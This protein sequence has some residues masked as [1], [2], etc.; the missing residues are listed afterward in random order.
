MK[1]TLTLLAALLFAPLAALHA[2]EA[3]RPA[4]DVGLEGSVVSVYPGPVPKGALTIASGKPAALWDREAYPLGNG[5][6]GAMIFGG[7]SSDAIAL[8]EQTFWSNGA[9]PQ[10]HQPAEARKA[11][12]H[13][14]EIRR[15]LQERK[16]TEAYEYSR[17]HFLP[18]TGMQR[19][20]AF[21][22]FANL[23]M[24]WRHENEKATA[25]AYDYVR[26]LDLTTA[27]CS[28]QYETSLTAALGN[29]SA[30][31]VVVPANSAR[32]RRE[33]FV[34]YPDQVMAM[35]VTANK[36]G[37]VSLVMAL[38]ATGSPAET[39]AEGQTLA[40]S[41]KRADNQLAFS[42]QVRVI[43][44]GGRVRTQGAHQIVE[45]ADAVTVLVALAT[46]YKAEYPA[47]RSGGDPRRVTSERIEAAAALGWDK[48][49]QR[50]VADHQ[51]LFNRV[52]LDLG[53]NDAPPLM[54]EDALGAYRAGHSD[55]ALERLLF[56]YGRYL[57]IASSRQGGLPSNLQGIWNLHLSP[58]WH[59]SFF[60]DMN[61]TM[62]YWPAHTANLREC[63][64]P[65]IG[66]MDRLQK[67]GQIEARDRW[68]AKGWYVSNSTDPS[69]TVPPSHRLTVNTAW[70][71]NP[72]YDHYRF[73]HDREYLRRTAYPL[74]KGAAE[75]YLSMLVP[76]SRTGEPVLSPSHS[77]EN[78]FVTP[79]GETGLLCEGSAYDQQTMHDLFSNCIE[80]AGILE[81]DEQFREE[82]RR[83]RDAIKPVKV[84]RFGQVQE[85]IEDWDREGDKH[86]HISQ[87]LALHPANLIDPIK[88]PEW[89][90]AARQ[91][92]EMRS[93]GHTGWSE[94][95]RCILWAR[96]GD[97]DN[98]H[99]RLQSLL[100]HL[101]LENL[102]CSHPPFQ[103]DGNYGIT[104]AMAEM[105]LQSDGEEIRL[106][107]AL[108]KAWPSGSVKGLCARGGLEVDIAW[109][110]G[111]LTEAVVRSAQG[112]PAKV[113][114][115]GFVQDLATQA[116]G[117]YVLNAGNAGLVVRPGGRDSATRERI[118][119]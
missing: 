52:S 55:P 119:K 58:P 112:G 74:M 57:M 96:L 93:M 75:F 113:R 53:S 19:Q 12:Q 86:R 91:T 51:A 81:V 83:V 60:L 115:G 61:L 59:S 54:T 16:F 101:I 29:L 20:G 71:M 63:F 68:G 14:P 18:S 100:Q 32:Y 13:L 98:A 44:E 103:M 82:L 89:A 31:T 77:P 104:G 110:G 10:G 6:I 114:W 73:T 88:T 33:Y 22:P 62:Q 111:R 69:G 49:K 92:L 11:Y 34:S 118:R 35:R 8:N 99:K 9:G 94:A 56:Q 7:V 109:S 23:R 79:E 67:P 2:A 70:L 102:F 26:A 87:L 24:R 21:Q 41:G 117:E 46:D 43:N 95:L 17:K 1:H 80:A 27:I 45:G 30:A 76:H 106:L 36:P 15:L 64:E 78:D 97:G 108:P 66:L 38:E 42:A 105:L 85:W 25:W 4:S 90:A 47:F 65:Y 5:N 40:F 37:I 72:I 3:V 50:H 28:V 107:P 39:V 48:L 116:G 84:G